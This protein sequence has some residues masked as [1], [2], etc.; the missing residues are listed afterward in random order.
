M[1]NPPIRSLVLLS[2]GIDSATALAMCRGDKRMAVGFHYGQQHD[3][4]LEYAELVAVAEGV[5]F[6][7]VKL[8]V[9]PKVNDLVFAGRNAVMIAVAASIAA[10]EGYERVVIGSN[11][12]DWQRFPDCRP[13][14]VKAMDAAMHS[15]YGIRVV[16]PL[17]H[18]S[19]AQVVAEACRLGVDLTRTWSCY[20]PIDGGNMHCGKCLACETRRL[21]MLAHPEA[22]KF[23]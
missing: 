18:L 17:L 21:A 9:M 16:A 2:G 1:A 14:F 23:A 7:V 12:S 15:G 10:Q 5:R 20:S 22:R 13:E 19:K 8:P 6:D 3:I 4:E 11:F